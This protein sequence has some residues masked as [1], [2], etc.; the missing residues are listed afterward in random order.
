MGPATKRYKVEKKSLRDP[1][2]FTKSLKRIIFRKLGDDPS[3]QCL[4]TRRRI[5]N[6]RNTS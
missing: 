6:C 5:P 1:Y 3:Y 2:S 4:S